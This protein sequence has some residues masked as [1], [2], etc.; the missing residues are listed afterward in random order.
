MNRKEIPWV[1]GNLH[2]F[3]NY[4]SKNLLHGFEN[5]LY[6]H[7]A[8][9]WAGR[10]G[11]S[12]KQRIRRVRKAGCSPAEPAPTETP[13][14]C[15][16]QHFLM[17]LCS[18][19]VVQM[20]IKAITFSSIRNRQV[21]HFLY[22]FFG[23]KRDFFLLSYSPWIWQLPKA[24]GSAFRRNPHLKCWIHERCHVVFFR[25]RIVET[26][27][28]LP[29]VSLDHCTAPAQIPPQSFH[30]V[31]L[32]I[33]ACSKLVPHRAPCFSHEEADFSGEWMRFQFD[34][35]VNPLGIPSNAKCCVNT[36][37]QPIQS[38]EPRCCSLGRAGGWTPGF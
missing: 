17:K 11:C 33:A 27:T 1:N 15:S 19:A 26:P 34:K 16:Q 3:E 12:G 32:F 21:T 31:L 35:F 10:G 7:F 28:L 37:C 14:S 8:D 30:S 22:I 25:N 23:V 20:R 38:D 5:D 29:H 9:L 2:G 13:R 4:F 36:G 24:R 6:I 18:V